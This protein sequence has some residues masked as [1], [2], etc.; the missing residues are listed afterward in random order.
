MSIEE[1]TRDG[2]PQSIPRHLTRD[3]LSGKPPSLAPKINLVMLSS[4]LNILSMW[5]IEEAASI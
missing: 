5:R 3:T 2:T 1:E 4:V